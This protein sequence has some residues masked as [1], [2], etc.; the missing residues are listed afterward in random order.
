MTM[1]K[2]PAFLLEPE[3]LQ[4]L[5]GNPQLLIVDLCEPEIYNDSHIPGAVSLSYNTIV[6][7]QTPVMGLL[8]DATTLSRVFSNI[9]LTPEHLVVAYDNENNAKACRLLWTLDCLG[10]KQLSLLNGGLTA[11]NNAGLPTNNQAANIHASHYN[12]KI[13]P[14]A[15]ADKAYIQQHLQDPTV[16][17]IDTRSNEE[18]TGELVRAKRGGHIPG[19]V[20]I[21]WLDT[22]DNN[23]D[24]RFKTT[25]ELKALYESAG[26]SEDK[27]I[28]TYCHTHQRSSH[29]YVVLKS[30]GY[31]NIKGYHG[32][33]SDWGNDPDTAIEQ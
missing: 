18:Y 19:A 10:H 21:N 15:I 29:S 23:N 28:I 16:V 12:A 25:D 14:T 26:I 27:Q 1:I 22:I 31:P 17:L 13:D 30:L 5:I 7:S 4:P 2:K 33:W 9:G 24:L 32:A 11:W 3:A 8:P 20:N 6:A